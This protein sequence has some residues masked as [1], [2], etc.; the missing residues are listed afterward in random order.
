[1]SLRACELFPTGEMLSSI[2]LYQ[3]HVGCLGWLSAT[4]TLSGRNRPFFSLF[5]H[6]R[7]S[8]SAIEVIPNRILK[9]PSQKSPSQ[10]I[11]YYNVK[12]AVFGKKAAF[13][14]QASLKS[15][16]SLSNLTARKM[17]ASFCTGTCLSLIITLLR[18]GRG[19][20]FN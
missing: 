12:Q 13:L 7:F 2:M 8:A 15:K 6:F 14:R 17:R 1:M 16:F 18:F 3:V 9:M 11:L 20:S 10:L 19:A 4:S 5:F